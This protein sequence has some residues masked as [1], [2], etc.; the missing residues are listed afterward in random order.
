MFLV[1]TRLY[2]K[3]YLKHRSADTVGATEGGG[4]IGF[5][6][7]NV[8]NSQ[9]IRKYDSTSYA[10]MFPNIDLTNW[11]TQ[12]N[13]GS[14]LA[15]Y[16][17][18]YTIANGISRDVSFDS[19]LPTQNDLPTQI[20]YSDLK[21]QN[22]IVDNFRTF[23]PLNFKDLPM[24]WG[25]INHHANYN[26]ELFTWQPRMVQRQY[27]NTRGTMNVDANS[28][29]T[30]VLI[31][32]GTVFSRD[33]QM[34]TNIGTLHKW[35]VIKGRSAQG[36][37]VMYWINTELKKAMRLGYDGSIKISDIQGMQSF[38]ANNLTWVAD[39][40]T[41]ADGEGICGTWDERYLCALWTVRGKRVI[42]AYDSTDTYSIN[43]VVSYTPGGFS[44]FEKTGE[45]YVSLQGSNLNHTPPNSGST[46]VWWQ[47]IPHT[48]SITVNGIEYKGI[49]YYNE[50]T[51][52]YNEQKNKFTSFY[53]FKPKI[54]LGWADTFLS[55]SPISNTGNVF[56]H[57]LG[58]YCLW[59]DSQQENGYI[60]LIFNQDV[61][62]AK[63][64]LA[65][66]M[67]TLI[68][69]FR[70]DFYTKK[71]QSFLLAADFE[72]LNDFWAAAIKNDILT[73]TTGLLNDEDTTKLFGQYIEI[74]LT[75][76]ALVYQKAVDCVL[77]FLSQNRLPNK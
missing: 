22:S 3:T 16:N 51:I 69:P 74:K 77:K 64:Y 10:W 45:F 17:E 41:P 49:D 66:W 8:V 23:L 18:G 11:L 37:D 15:P 1:E 76:E 32:D 42:A 9:M 70:I 20:R 62:S 63:Q 72:N 48:G 68:V 52:E 33:G 36:N 55:P 61:N 2:K 73:S 40:D 53:T 25:E 65:L 67:A 60:T 50:Y 12:T 35:S 44:T 39:K 38:F 46:S 5:Y 27:F 34:V 24:T 31:G 14:P 28:G 30:A 4:G 7:Q 29:S 43:D 54:Y 75:F 59:Y 21:P 13:L 47:M 19:T 71:H 26:G 6:S 57:R 56:E 58:S